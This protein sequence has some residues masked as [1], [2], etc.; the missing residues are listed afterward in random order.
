MNKKM[1]N[2]EVRK[3]LAELKY[4]GD[5]WGEEFY[6]P[7]V[8]SEE[9][10]DE[11]LKELKIYSD[12]GRAEMEGSIISA[13]MHYE[14]IKKSHIIS[15]RSVGRYARNLEATLKPTENFKHHLSN[16]YDDGGIAGVS[17]I[18]DAVRELIAEGEYPP[19]AARYINALY[20]LEGDKNKFDWKGFVSFL[21][22]YQ[23]ACE[24]ALEK[25]MSKNAA[26]KSKPLE[27][28]IS[29][30]AINWK[31]H[32]PIPFIAGKY[33]EGIGYN[34]DAIHIMKK[35]ME[36]L[37]RSVTLQAIANKLTEVNKISKE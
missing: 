13:A 33:H 25:P 20:W 16:I 14:T 37:D 2:D 17:P 18:L 31:N 10:L 9:F 34:S 32:S 30:L 29:N 28:W 3:K 22:F 6:K 1:D 15:Y 24:R 27:Q 11:I 21:D 7:N 19:Q 26:H 36:P 5:G 12:D 35:I 23:S 8:Y 4:Q